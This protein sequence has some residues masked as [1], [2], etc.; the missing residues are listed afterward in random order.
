MRRPPRSTPC[1][2]TTLF[3]SVRAALGGAEDG[4]GEREHGK[5]NESHPHPSPVS[6]DGASAVSSARG[7]WTLFCWKSC[8]AA[9]GRSAT[10]EDAASHEPLRT[11]HPRRR[12]RPRHRSEEHTS[13][14]QSRQ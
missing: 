2:Y 11:R 14:L 7:S 9:P 5:A 8:C 1:P 10:C 3:R 13:E 6:A 4:R 12:D